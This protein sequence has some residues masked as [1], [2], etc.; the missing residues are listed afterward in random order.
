MQKVY[1]GN[2]PYVFVSYSHEDRERVFGLINDLMICSCNIWYDIGLHSGNDWSEEIAR[3]LYGAECIMLMI[4]NNS[5]KSEYV[6]DEINFARAKNKKIYPVFLEDI[7]LPL[8][9]DFLLGRTQAI[10]YIDGTAE[11]SRFKLRDKIKN[12][13]PKNVFTVTSSPF[14]SGRK[15]MFYLKDTSR[16]FPEGSY[17]AGE[18]LCSFEISAVNS[19]DGSQITLCRYE[20]RPG[21]DMAFTI[22]NVAV[23]DDPYFCDDDSKIV[24]I[25]L[26]LNFMGKYPVPWPDF[27]AVLT[28]AISRLESNMPR[29]TLPDIRLTQSLANEDYNFAKNVLEEI[30]QSFMPKQGN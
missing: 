2:E 27:D 25:S 15:N 26:V 22:N 20:A 6:R 9:L 29:I 13:L 8:G 14:Y 4:T 1:E 18:E 3:R 12:Q 28:I 30:E 5:V 11:D 19:D 10:S 23:F 21:Y 17:F 7:A 24:F 16:P